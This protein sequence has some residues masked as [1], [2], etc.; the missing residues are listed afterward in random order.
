MDVVVTFETIEHIEDY[1]K[2]MAE[3]KRVLKP[4]GLAVISTPNDLEFAEGNHFHIHEFEHDELKK[5]IG[6]HFKHQDDYFQTTL[7]YVELARLE[8]LASGNTRTLVVDNFASIKPEQVLYFYVLCSDQPIKSG[9]ESQYALGEHYS[10]RYVGSLRLDI[11]AHKELMQ[12]REMES[13]ARDVLLEAE[14]KKSA[15]IPKLEEEIAQLKA[16]LEPFLNSRYFII[17]RKLFEYL[18]KGRVK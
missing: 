7:K 4:D 13:D 2:F 8:D 3:I 17:R 14:R 9:I 10:D 11:Q 5:L 15:I 1:E 16:D 18:K 6:T 12:K